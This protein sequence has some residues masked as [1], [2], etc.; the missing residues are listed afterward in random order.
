MVATWGTMSWRGTAS[1]GNRIELFTRSG[2][3]ATPDE[4][5]SAWSAAYTNAEGSPI[6]SPKTRYLQWRA[7]LTRQGRRSGADL[8]HGRLSSAQPA[9]AGPL[10]HRASARHRVPEAVHHRGTGSRGLRGSDHAGAQAGHGRRAARGANALGRRAYQKGLETLQWR[11]DDENDDEL[12]YDVLFRREG[13]TTWKALRRAV[14]DT[15][16]VW[17]TNTVPNGSYFI[18]VV[19]SDGPSNPAGI[20]LT[21]EL[22][23]AAFDVDNTPPV[24]AVAGVRVD[25]G[26]TIVTFDVKDDHSPIQRVEFS[27]DGQRWRGVF[28]TDGIADSRQEHYELVVEGVLTERGL[29]LRAVDSMNNVET[30]HVD[31]P[32]AAIR[33]VE[34]QATTRRAARVSVPAWVPR[35]AFEPAG[36]LAGSGRSIGGLFRRPDRFR[37]DEPHHFPGQLRR[38]GGRAGARDRVEQLF[39]DLGLAGGVRAGWRAA[40]QDSP[41]APP[42]SRPRRA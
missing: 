41:A 31:P 36:L 27:E 24:I 11:A 1:G 18:K 19:A 34:R 7:V 33:S 28:P 14:A 5:W 13:E 3:T 32:L 6:T 15:I 9:A 8:G 40:P 37:R 16:L 22:E 42:E 4:T 30:A 21:G 12:V 25:R 17:D 35:A 20:A 38:L 39:D 2:N 23:S 26:R 29:T 10:G